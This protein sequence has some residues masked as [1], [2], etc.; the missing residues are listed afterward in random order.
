MSFS[1]TSTNLA[2]NLLDWL[3]R[4][5]FSSHKSRQHQKI[6]DYTQSTDGSDYILESLSEP[7]KACMT[8]F[9]KDIKPSDYIILRQGCES[10]YYQVEEIDYYAD[11]SDM[12]IA[13]LR[14]CQN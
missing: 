14:Q 5:S 13:L 10:C 7:L 3:P 8:G 2:L 9:G 12:W 11:P 1:R 4:I 6:H